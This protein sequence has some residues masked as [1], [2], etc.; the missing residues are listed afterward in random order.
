MQVLASDICIC[1]FLKY[2]YE[3]FDESREK[4]GKKEEM[5][6]RVEGKGIAL[7]FVSAR[8][9]HWKSRESIEQSIG[10]ENSRV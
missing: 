1:I 3:L 8:V 6:R 2:E 7:P 10:W 5:K 9:R 4:Q